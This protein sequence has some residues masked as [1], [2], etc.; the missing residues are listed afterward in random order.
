VPLAIYKHSLHSEALIAL[1]TVAALLAHC[2][3]STA[4][5]KQSSKGQLCV[6]PAQYFVNCDGLLVREAKLRCGCPPINVRGGA[7]TR[8][9]TVL[10]SI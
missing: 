9:T 4:S 2:V 1:T 6:I 10:R 5:T 3:R 8:A 7:T